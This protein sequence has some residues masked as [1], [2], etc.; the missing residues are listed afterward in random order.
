V[1]EAILRG[2]LLAASNTGG[3]S[4]LTAGCKGAFTFDPGNYASLAIALDMIENLSKENAIDLTSQSR[5]SFLKKFKTERMSKGYD[6]LLS[7]TGTSKA[8]SMFC[9][10]VFGKDLSQFNVLDVEQLNA[11]IEQLDIK[12]EEQ[13]DVFTLYEQNIGMLTPIIADELLDAE[14]VY[15]A[16]WIHHPRWVLQAIPSPLRNA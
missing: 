5:N 2:R 12:P 7:R 3:V 11:L 8:Y 9:E 10:R 14:K 16:N 6:D 13:L 1:S 4:E 15:P